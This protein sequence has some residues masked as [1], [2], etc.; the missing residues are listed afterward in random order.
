VAA[1][2]HDVGDQPGALPLLQYALTGLFE[3][4]DDH[5]LTKA[6]YQ[7]I[8]GVLGALGRQAEEVY[9]RLNPAAQALARQLFLRLVTLGE[10]IEDTRRRAL[11]AELEALTAG[12]EIQTV[13]DTF[14]RHRLLAFD[15]DP[16][17]RGATVE[18]AHEAL[19]RKWPRLRDWLS[20]SRADVR[21]QRQLAAAAAEWQGANR[22]AGYLL[23]GSRLAQFEGWAA[24]T[25]LALTQ[26]EREYLEASVAER[27]AQAAAEAERQRREL[28]TAKKLAETEKRRA[29]E[30]ARNAT[31]LRQRAVYLVFA[32][33]AA[34]ILLVAT[35]GLAQLSNQNLVTARAANT[36]AVAEIQNRS[37]AEANAQ[38]EA[39]SRSTAEVQA[40]VQKN[41]A[42]DSQAMA[43]AEA[44]SR[45]TAEANAVQAQAGAE[46][47]AALAFARE[48]GA[49]AEL[50][51]TIDPQ[52]S[53]L[54]A[55]Q[56]I[57]VTRSAGLGTPWDMQQTLHDVMPAQRVRWRLEQT[58][59]PSKVAYSADGKRITFTCQSDADRTCVIDAATRQ[60]LRV[61]NGY[62]FAYNPDEKLLVTGPEYSTDIRG[63]A[64]LWD[65]VTGRQV[66]TLTGSDQHHWSFAF[67]GD[68]VIAGSYR[69]DIWDL[70]AW[71]AAGAP[72]GVTLTATAQ[73]LA[74]FSHRW[75]N[76]GLNFSPDGRRLAAACDL[77]NTT[78]VYDMP[79]GRQLFTLTGDTGFVTQVVFSPDGRRLA[80]GSLDKTVRIWDV[81]TGQ[82]LLRLNPGDVEPDLAFSPDGQRL[83]TIADELVTLWDA[84]TGARL[85]TLPNPGKP[86]GLAFSPEG[87]RLVVVMS[88]MLQEWDVTP[89]GPGELA[90]VP[91]P[92]L[93]D[94]NNSPDGSRFATLTTNGFLTAYEAATLQP[95]W[96]TRAFTGVY[97]WT[98]MYCGTADYCG[99]GLTSLGNLVSFSAGNSRLMAGDN[100][101]F[102]VWDLPSQQPLRVAPGA[103]VVEALS[104]D[105]QRLAYAAGYPPATVISVW[106][107]TTQKQQTLAKILD[108]VYSMEFSPD[109]SRL[110]A[111][112]G[113]IAGTG[114][115]NMGGEVYIWDLK[116][117]TMP[118]SPSIKLTFDGLFIG[119]INF[120]PDGRLL[121]AGGSADGAIVWDLVTARPVLTLPTSLEHVYD[122]NFSP[123]GKYLVTGSA[124]RSVQVWDAQ[125]G[126]EVL[127]Y[128]MADVLGYR[129]FFTPGNKAVVIAS[130][131]QAVHL[132]AFL[133]FDALVAEARRRP[134]RDWQP[135]ECVKY[136]HTTTCPKKP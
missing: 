86:F 111:A 116:G 35:V 7:G 19:L 131:G 45:A 63:V 42:L 47:Q 53:L 125:T 118:V 109:G 82:E 121:A 33:G 13:L 34:L 80:T 32:L 44:Q 115:C 98:G 2:M 25:D 30:Q 5:R 26:A 73:S 107:A 55:L 75:Y 110:V 76:F 91:N 78:R 3:K 70:R 1:I 127:R 24:S 100:T 113:G 38:A 124:N 62:G 103:L 128:P 60:T 117:D 130:S 67:D 36:Q 95:L 72:E 133:D 77:D 21:L 108:C 64:Y 81:A 31:R 105:G 94:F 71:R 99:P 123:D 9:T 54:L 120:S 136:L 15:R 83:A 97:A 96:A 93:A 61:Y 112:G 11:R 37:T 29:E 57:S 22:E 84:N 106:D 74:C 41:A 132:N 114:D 85:L 59:W 46:Q 129:A 92:P 102:S 89:E 104:P 49:A 135:A 122:I 16:V 40:V 14:G 90:V 4:R 39:Y 52:L 43:Q 119:H 50:Q 56:A 20:A 51:M 87:R 66:V 48:L 69:A 68:T 101:A 134:L 17:T 8:G 28:K 10:G 23:A 79:S 18:V 12:T 58:F 65:A 27:Q 88:G 6:A 126:A